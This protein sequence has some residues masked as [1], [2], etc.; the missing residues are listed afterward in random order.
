MTRRRNPFRYG[1]PVGI[2]DLIDRDEE[3]A[4]LLAAAD[5]GNNARL[6]AP[7]RYGKTSLLRRVLG[8]AAADQWA[9]VY[10]DFF[11]VV[12]I[13]DVTERIE[14]AYGASLTGPTARWFEGLR[15]TLRPSLKAGAP[16]AATAEVHLDP[17][18]APLL[19]RLELP[20]KVFDKWGTRVLVVFDEFQ[21]VLTAQANADAVIRS[22]IQ[23]HGNAAGYIFAGSHV[24]MMN[25]LFTDRRRAFY[26]QALPVALPPLP[27]QAT[28]DFLEDRFT[29]TGK[30][31]GTALGTLLDATAG[32]PQ[33]TML[34]AHHVWDRTSV[35]GAADEATVSAALTQVLSELGDEFRALW[36][37]L[38]TAQRRVLTLVGEETTSPFSRNAP[39]DRGRGTRDAL[40]ALLERAD[41]TSDPTSVS[42]YRVVDPMLAAWLRAGR[43]DHSTFSQR[44]P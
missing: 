41:I 29:G 33:R 9:T 34:L 16:G 11:G 1:G 3:A 32:H 43:S 26:S 24:G 22:V 31:L 6:A 44:G 38:P 10:V 35:G 39:T 27:P 21:E 4:T 30:S 13:A 14:R 12:T 5:E 23:H 36:S 25:E 8:E 37:G 18:T 2:D 40:D 19:E 17:V 20:R 42:R 15:R 7:R 28:A